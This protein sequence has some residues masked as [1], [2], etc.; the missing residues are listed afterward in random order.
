MLRLIAGHA[1]FLRSACTRSTTLTRSLDEVGSK[2]GQLR[3]CGGSAR[4]SSLGSRACEWMKQEGARQSARGE[5]TR[6]LRDTLT[7]PCCPQCPTLRPPLSVQPPNQQAT[8]CPARSGRWS[9]SLR[10]CDEML[11]SVVQPALDVVHPA[12]QDSPRCAAAHLSA[13]KSCACAPLKGGGADD[14]AG[15]D[16]IA[17][18]N[19]VRSNTS[20]GSRRL[21]PCV[22]P[23]HAGASNRQSV[24]V[25][26]DGL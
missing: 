21:C 25:Y 4:A 1:A 24:Y 14:D 18:K 23:P 6:V 20:S 11:E 2:A 19:A 16:A 8:L 5:V 3:G 9:G 26:L 17:S 7:H 22:S 12:R 10:A 15:L 13:R